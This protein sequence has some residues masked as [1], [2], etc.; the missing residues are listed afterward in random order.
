MATNPIENTNLERSLIISKV[1]VDRR[2]SDVESSDIY[3]DINL[4]YQ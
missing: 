4:L 3:S 1:E 2:I